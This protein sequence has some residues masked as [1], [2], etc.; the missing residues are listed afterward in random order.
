MPVRRRTTREVEIKLRVSGV[1]GLVRE[2]SRLGTASHGRVFERNILYDTPDS[3]FRRRGCL[4]RVRTET[5]APSGAIRGGRRR[6]V[7]TSKASAPA[8]PGS[9]YK[10][11]LERQALVRFPKRWDRI[12]RSIGLRP[13]FRY[14]KYRTTFRLPGLYVDLDETPVG[15]FLELEGTPKAI[16]RVARALGFSSRD[17]IRGTYWDLYAADCRDRGRLLRNMLFSS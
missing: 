9:R 13:G 6:S 3:D 17:Y 4:L 8:R 12:L 10:Q 11:K 14:E 5:P 7:I 15:V 1:P 2:L 16:D